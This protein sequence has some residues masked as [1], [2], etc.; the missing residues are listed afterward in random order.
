MHQFPTSKFLF[1][2]PYRCEYYFQLFLQSKRASF[3][4]GS[5]LAAYCI[6]NLPG[7]FCFLSLVSNKVA[8]TGSMLDNNAIHKKTGL[9]KE[10]ITCLIWQDDTTSVARRSYFFSDS[11]PWGL[12]APSF[13]TGCPYQKL[14]GTLIKIEIIYNY[15]IVGFLHLIRAAMSQIQCH[16]RISMIR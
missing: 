9:P 11:R 15:K 1:F 16:S 3:I 4:C 6:C 12:C 13:P 2:Y 8:Y 7:T 5:Q 14:N 10:C